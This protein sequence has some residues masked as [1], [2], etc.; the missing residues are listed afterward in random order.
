MFFRFPPDARWNSDRA[1]VE[2]GIGIGEYEG[3]VRV[4]RRVFQSLLDQAPTPERCLEDYHLQ[5][6]RLELIAERKVR[7]RQLTDDG[8]IEITGRDLRERE[9]QKAAGQMTLE[10]IAVP[11]EGLG[12]QLDQ[13]IAWL[14]ANCAAGSWSMTP[15]GTSSVVNDALAIYFLDPVLARAFVSRWC[16]GCR[17]KV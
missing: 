3:V 15:S 7:R 5:R 17:I 14:N 13:M 4:G 1:A 16:I 10:L 8:N 9:A 11:P 12:N 2:F 6:T